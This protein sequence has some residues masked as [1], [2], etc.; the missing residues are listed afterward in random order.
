MELD[1]ID[2]IDHISKQQTPNDNARDS[3]KRDFLI[4]DSVRVTDFSAPVILLLNEFS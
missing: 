3:Y 2:Y 4:A 1:P